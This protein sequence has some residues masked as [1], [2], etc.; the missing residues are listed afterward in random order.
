M[1]KLTSQLVFIAFALLLFLT[2][3]DD[4]PSQLGLGIIPPEDRVYYNTIEF[5]ISDSVTISDF[6]Q[7]YISNQDNPYLGI[8]QDPFLGTITAAIFSEFKLSTRP[9]KISNA[10]ADSLVL[11]LKPSTSYH[12]YKN[13]I[14]FGLYRINTLINSDT[15]YK[16]ST[17]S[18]KDYV[19]EQS[20]L[21]TFNIDF[22]KED[23]LK[24]VEIH[25]PIS[26]ANELINLLESDTASLDSIAA[27]RNHNIFGIYIKP[28]DYTGTGTIGKIDFTS[29][30]NS[31]Y[32][33]NFM[34]LYFNAD[35]D[36]SESVND[37]LDFDFRAHYETN[38]K[39]DT[40]YF[41]KLNYFT[42]DYSSATYHNGYNGVKNDSVYFIFS[43]GGEKLKLN[44]GN[45]KYLR[46]LKGDSSYIVGKAELVL[47]YD[48]TFY[49]RSYINDQNLDINLLD[50][51]T[52]YSFSS[53]FSFNVGNFSV[54]DKA[55]SS[56]RIDITEYVQK[57]LN[58]IN[59]PTQ[60]LITTQSPS[61][62]FSNAILKKRGIKLIVKY[63]K[64]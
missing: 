58:G 26:Y 38:Q 20:L 22:N 45:L 3:C 37:F 34:R 2:A 5:D 59:L 47:P 42:H 49:K 19:N 43:Q 31:G 14:T 24:N 60:T 64:I 6:P 1:H 11:F 44:M 56:Y 33:G 51:D 17:F 30:N 53:N 50:S 40:I 18:P 4:E 7:E 36:T 15:L 46:K 25:L 12:G 8:M 41:R 9:Y 27:L 21:T 62:V 63:S 28:I 10:K 32:S 13:K 16:Y 23:T 29:T 61:S 54:K 39:E 35:V 52:A 48:S 55:I 57:Y